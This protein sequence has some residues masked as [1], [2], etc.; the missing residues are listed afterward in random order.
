[1]KMDSKRMLDMGAVPI[2]HD[3]IPLPCILLPGF[4]GEFPS[5]VMWE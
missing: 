1:M 5:A 2:S 4:G 3:S